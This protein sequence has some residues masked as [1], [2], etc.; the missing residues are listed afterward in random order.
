MLLMAAPWVLHPDAVQAGLPRQVHFAVMH[1][2]FH[3]LGGCPH[4]H[5]DMTSSIGMSGQARADDQ[6][7]CVPFL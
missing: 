7:G 3:P 1:Q 2:A 6:S 5:I 4:I